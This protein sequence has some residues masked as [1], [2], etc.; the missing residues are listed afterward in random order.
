MFEII[1]FFAR[2]FNSMIKIEASLAKK[3]AKQFTAMLLLDMKHHLKHLEI[4]RE[5]IKLWILSY[6]E[7]EFLMIFFKSQNKKN[8]TLVNIR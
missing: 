8:E 4:V 1:E 6:I 3:F 7:F 5:E 2:H